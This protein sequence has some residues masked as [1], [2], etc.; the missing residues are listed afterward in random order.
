MLFDCP[1]EG[2]HDIMAL[3]IGVLLDPSRVSLEETLHRLAHAGADGVQLYTSSGK[4]APWNMS[5]ARRRE[6]VAGVASAGLEISALCGDLGGHGFERPDESRERIHKTEQILDLAAELSVPV[7]TTHIGVVP[8]EHDERYHALVHA[9]REIASYAGMREL[10]VGIETGPEPPARL[11]Q[12][13]EDVG[14]ESLGVNLDPANLAMIQGIDAVTAL[15]ELRDYVVYTHAKDGRMVKPGNAQEIYD[16][17]ADGDS[18]FPFDEYFIETPLGEGAVNFPSYVAAL[19]RLG[20][21]GYL[22]IEREA[23]SDWATDVE[24]GISFLRE[25]IKG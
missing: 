3:R 18:S 16:A 23:G 14:E 5:E 8:E 2:G 6:I 7:V 9:L 4:S 24:R 13:I 1:E 15:R 12:F 20:F 25:Q 21:E 17:F 10:R 22:T 11:K 19:S